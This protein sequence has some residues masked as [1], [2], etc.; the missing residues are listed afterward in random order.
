MALQPQPSTCFHL[1]PGQAS[2][3]TAEQIKQQTWPLAATVSMVIGQG[4]NQAF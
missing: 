4:Y 1:Q 2:A 3:E